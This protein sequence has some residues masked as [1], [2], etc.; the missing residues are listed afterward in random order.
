MEKVKFGGGVLRSVRCLG[1]VTRDS[2][3][4]VTCELTPARRKGV[5][6]VDFWADNETGRKGKCHSSME[7]ARLEYLSQERQMVTSVWF[8]TV[9]CAFTWWGENHGKVLGE[10]WT[11][12]DFHYKRTVWYPS[13]RCRKDGAG[14]GRSDWSL[15]SN[16]GRGAAAGGRSWR[17][18]GKRV[19]K[20]EESGFLLSIYFDSARLDLARLCG[21]SQG[22]LQLLL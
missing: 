16:A 14:A 2:T 4:K 15:P 9:R 3:G 21:K 18:T 11:Y 17:A 8:W 20:R 22:G 7:R 6:H 13:R 10:E 12:S 5:D 19:P 1:V